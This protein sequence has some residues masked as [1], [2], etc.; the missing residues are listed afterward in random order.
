MSGKFITFEGGEGSG[1]TSIIQVLSEYLQ[2]NGYDVITSREP[3]GSKIAEQIREVILN[4]DNIAMTEETET[5]LYAASRIQHLKEKVLPALEA[6]KV[7]LCD[8]YVDSSLAYQGYARNIGM[9][10][11]LNAN[12]FALKYMPDL[13]IFID[14][15]P[16]IAMA[17]LN[18]RE[19]IDRLDLESMDFHNRVY[20]GY[21][22]VC[23]MYPNRVVKINGNQGLDK[24]MMD[25]HDV[26]LKFLE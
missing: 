21:M 17:R 16:E 22:K 10:E 23:E 18:N 4:V 13:T 8:R 9:E 7:I 2:A 1:K 24:V 3:G 26:V 6:N 11:V 12:A 25:V 19:K 15:K 20:E 14:V 5:L